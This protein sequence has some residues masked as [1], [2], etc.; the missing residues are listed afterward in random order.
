MKGFTAQDL[1]AC[2]RRGVF[3]MAETRH[4]DRIYLVDP[5]LRGVLPLHGFYLPRRLGRTI[6]QAPFQ[7]RVD[8]AFR[9]VITALIGAALG[10]PLGIFLAALVTRALGQ[11]DLRFELPFG[12]LV[13]LVIVAVFAGLLAAITPARRAAK[14]DPLRALQYE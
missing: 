14:L 1:I 9:P 6:R 2:Y 3:P 8:A 12:Q 4:D 11:Y 10:L 7:I 5:D 13:V